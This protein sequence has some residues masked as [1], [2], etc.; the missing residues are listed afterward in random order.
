MKA[1]SR[2]PGFL[3]QRE[4]PGVGSGGPGEGAVAPSHPNLGCGL[5]LGYHLP[6]IRAS[7]S[8]AAGTF[9]LRGGSLPGPPPKCDCPTS[10]LRVVAAAA[11]QRGRREAETEARLR[12]SVSCP[13]SP[14]QAGPAPPGAA[15]LGSERV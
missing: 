15:E 5:G 3:G 10:H 11:S 12:P 14:G 4:K 13:P 7:F 1:E 6:G 2:V 8:S 9:L